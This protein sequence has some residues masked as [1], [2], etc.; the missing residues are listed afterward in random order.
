M[1]ESMGDGYTKQLENTLE[2]QKL[3]FLS[4]TAEAKHMLYLYLQGEEACSM[5]ELCQ[6]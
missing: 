1:H 3:G 6:R 5:N 4:C 2:T